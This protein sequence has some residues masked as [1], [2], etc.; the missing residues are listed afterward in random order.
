MEE[1][2]QE[3]H[4]AT[5][6]RRLCWGRREGLNDA[7]KGPA[8]GED[9]GLDFTR[10]QH[11]PQGVPAVGEKDQAAARPTREGTVLR[12]AS[13]E[14]QQ[15]PSLF[16]HRSFRVRSTLLA[17]AGSRPFQPPETCCVFPLPGIPHSYPPVPKALLQ[18]PL[19]GS[20]HPGPDWAH[21]LLNPEAQVV[22]PSHLARD[23][24]PSPSALLPLGKAYQDAAL[25]SVPP[26]PHFC[27]HGTVTGGCSL[28][29]A[30][31]WP[32]GQCC[33][34]GISR[35]SSTYCDLLG[36]A[37]VSKGLQHSGSLE[38]VCSWGPASP[39]PHLQEHRSVHTAS[40]SSFLQSPT[41]EGGEGAAMPQPQAATKS[42]GCHG[43][44]M[45]M[46]RVAT[47]IYRDKYCSIVDS[48]ELIN[49]SL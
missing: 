3:V 41:S 9:P 10:R 35:V 7:R 31:P 42:N 13:E 23:H 17:T 29:K 6:G 24:P 48:N 25:R 34:T 21:S 4:T 38:N 11:E 27:L 36:A 12:E 2:G 30:L 37:A 45:I 32:P 47:G 15:Q 33:P 28:H 26:R 14:A 1:T 20:P 18:A 8:A 43:N 40:T 16:C 22:C 5:P 19:P 44:R 46:M 49:S 39:M